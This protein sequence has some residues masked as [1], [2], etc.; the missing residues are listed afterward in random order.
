LMI[1]FGPEYHNYTLYKKFDTLN[2]LEQHLFLNSHKIVKGGLV[3]TY[4]DLEHEETIIGGLLRIEAKVGPMNQ[5][6]RLKN[7]SVMSYY[8]LDEMVT[9]NPLLIIKK[10]TSIEEIKFKTSMKLWQRSAAEAVRVIS[11]S[12]YYGRMSASVSAQAF[13]IPNE[14]SELH[15]FQGCVIH[16]TRETNLDKAEVLKQ[17][18]FLYPRWDEY[19]FYDDEPRS[20]SKKIRDPFEIQTIRKLDLH[21][22]NT[23]LSYSIYDILN[24]FWNNIRPEEFRESKMDRDWA[25]LTDYF[26]VLDTSYK[27]TLERLGGDD[28]RFRKKK[29]IMLILKLYTLRDRS[30]KAVCHGPIVMI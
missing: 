13:Y 3:E 18:K 29:L 16:L 27:V 2:P 24:F 14:L 6:K 8:E 5:L 26:P 4:A 19:N 28:D 17:I 30:I 15:T 1:A 21:K 22:F 12:I 9:D 11:P 23:K 20:I 25:I 7:N 10:P